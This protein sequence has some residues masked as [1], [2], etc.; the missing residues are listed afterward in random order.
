MLLNYELPEREELM[1]RG[2]L[3]GEEILFCVPYN[4]NER[5]SYVDGWTVITR[6][7][8]LFLQDG[9][10]LTQHAIE[11]G[12]VYTAV[13]Q[14][15]SGR[16]EFCKDGADYRLVCYTMEHVPRY[17]YIQRI[18]NELAAD[19]YPKIKSLDD[20]KKCPKCG[21]PYL[22]RTKFC[23]NCTNKLSS[24]KRLT[25]F[26]KKRWYLYVTVMLLF[27]G[28][29]AVMLF[30][31]L[32]NRGVIDNAIL[33]MSE[34]KIPVSM[35]TILFYILLIAAC[36][37]VTSALN[38]GRQFVTVKASASMERDIKDV[39]YEKVQ[40]LSIGYLDTRKTGDLMNRINRDSGLVKG[41]M[42]NVF[43]QAI[44]EVILL[45]GVIAILFAYNW[46]LALL[47]VLPVP[48]VIL[49]CYLYREKMDKMYHAQW[50]KMDKFTSLLN[51]I[52]NGIR[53]VKAFGQE[54]REIQRFQ[55]D[56]NTVREITA[57]NEAFFYTLSPVI[58]FMIGF[59]SFLVLFYG[60][61]LVLN[62]KLTV[63]ELW[64]FST[65]ASYLYNRLDWFTMLPR[66][67][68][69]ATTC[70]QRIFA[71]LDEDS[72]VEDAENAEKKQISGEV[73]LEDVTFGY[74]SY[75]PVLKE[76]S[77]KINQ[78]EM[79]GLV[80]HSGAGKST[81]INLI[82]RLYDADE[83]RIKIDGVNLQNLSQEAY[84]ANIGVVLQETFLFSGSILDNIRY[85]KP[86]ATVEEVIRAARIANA[87][88]FIMRFPN[89]YD[90]RVGERGQRL[91][92]GERQRISIARAVL[93][94]PKILILDEATAS[95][96]TET[97]YLIQ[98]ALGRLIQ[99]RT[100]IA[101]AHR[102]ST[103]KNANRLA[104]FKEGELMELGTHDELIAKKGIYYTLVMAQRKMSAIK[105][106]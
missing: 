16:L 22:R 20:E 33:P 6:T 2:K 64:Q 5:G 49:L 46:K 41:F 74:Q 26:V 70:L 82:M 94:D 23:P 17:A 30:Q 51:D 19:R 14:Q 50:V 39:V 104:V 86:D 43:S 87:H 38:M 24:F 65:Y 15:A 13:D 61:S 105:G 1:L 71:L 78:G 100:T 99:N 11:E 92:G 8:V 89:G 56:A 28:N 53:V 84:K 40:S 54:K 45:I 93:N 35:G 62:M 18:L 32:V 103:L 25:I 101:I 58:K 63:G 60:G 44:N 85:A 76:V 72:E 48:L 34:G 73:E 77:L 10:F 55:Q 57:K 12:N 7:R 68:N 31:P 36:N 102:L 59:G 3:S 42:Q 88:D 47:T 21:R 97:E 9:E 27:W 69:E 106:V 91:S 83:G 81:V 66:S 80:G 29:A 75:K 96:D 52:L 95:V 4:L 98:E 37:I 79:V 67:I 90:T